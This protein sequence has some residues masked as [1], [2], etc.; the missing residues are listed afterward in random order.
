MLGWLMVISA[1]IIM[2]KAADCEHRSSLLWGSLTFMICVGFAYLIPSLPFINIF[3]GLV[4]SFSL[5][6]TANIV[7]K[8]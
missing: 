4:V 2:V 7:Q 6:F 8:R 3:L 1:V 5:M